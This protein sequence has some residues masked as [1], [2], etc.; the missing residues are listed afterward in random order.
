MVEWNM[1]AYTRR[2]VDSSYFDLVD[3]YFRL[4]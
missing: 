4:S 2:F 3:I 1:R